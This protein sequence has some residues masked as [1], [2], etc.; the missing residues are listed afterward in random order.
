M[1]N[2]ENEKGISLADEISFLAEVEAGGHIEVIY[3]LGQAVPVTPSSAHH[4]EVEFVQE[5]TN[6]C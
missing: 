6:E 4:D 2:T 5:A 1:M 3:P